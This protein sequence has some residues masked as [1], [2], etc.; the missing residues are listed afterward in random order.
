MFFVANWNSLWL[1]TVESSV[2]KTEKPSSTQFC[3]LT[4]QDQSTVYAL[5]GISKPSNLKNF[6][7]DRYE[8]PFIYR[9]L[10]LT[11][12]YERSFKF[13]MRKWNRTSNFS[14]LHQQFGNWRSIVQHQS[15]LS[16]TEKSTHQHFKQL[17]RSLEIQAKME[18][19]VRKSVRILN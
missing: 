16:L 12:D 11:H 13:N 8:N 14:M 18:R 9:K 4:A 19:T 15:Q 1:T 6:N 3:L 10:F 17:L 7:Q 5:N 2:R